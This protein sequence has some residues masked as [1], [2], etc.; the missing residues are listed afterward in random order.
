M[1]RVQRLGEDGDV[2][3]SRLES[4]RLEL[5]HRVGAAPGQARVLEDD[6]HEGKWQ[7]AE[8]RRVGRHTA[9]YVAIVRGE[10][11]AGGGAEGGETPA[12]Q[13]LGRHRR[14]QHV[15]ALARRDGQPA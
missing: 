1:L 14:A 10:D 11:D 12:P 5:G 15:G 8:P 7:A 2:I 13:C 3:Q 9:A 6:E 4:P